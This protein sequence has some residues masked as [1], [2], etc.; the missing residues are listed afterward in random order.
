MILKK[1]EIE[2]P[3]VARETR[4]GGNIAIIGEYD[5]YIA[6]AKLNFEW[7]TNFNLQP[8]DTCHKKFFCNDRN[9]NCSRFVLFDKVILTSTNVY[10]KTNASLV[11]NFSRDQI[12]IQ[13]YIGKNGERFAVKIK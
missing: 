9:I 6:Y 13:K 8:R 4:K 5:R 10:R 1:F 7:D 11:K 12:A 2:S 3:Y